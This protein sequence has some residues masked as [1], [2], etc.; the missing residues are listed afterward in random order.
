MRKAVAARLTQ[1]AAVKTVGLALIGK[2]EVFSQDK[3]CRDRPRVVARAFANGRR[4]E[5]PETRKTPTGGEI[6][7][8]REHKL[9]EPRHV[10]S[11]RV[12]VAR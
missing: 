8:A 2:E 9:G 1:P 7:H 10:P 11:A 4:Q 6:A 3:Q 5:R 12:T